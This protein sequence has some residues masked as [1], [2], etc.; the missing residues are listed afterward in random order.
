M[1]KKTEPFHIVEGDAKDQEAIIRVRPAIE[2][3]ITKEIGK[4][5]HTEL[6]WNRYDNGD[7]EG[8]FWYKLS[9]F[10]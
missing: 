4:F 10:K 1:S 5:E 6:Q 2:D 9:F 3:E 7:K 8:T